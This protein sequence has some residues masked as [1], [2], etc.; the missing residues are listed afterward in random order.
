M[1]EL[2]LHQRLV[3]P[4]PVFLT[5]DKLDKEFARRN[6]EAFAKSSPPS[7]VHVATAPSIP[8]TTARAFGS[9]QHKTAERT[10]SA[11]KIAQLN[12]TAAVDEAHAKLAAAEQVCGMQHRRDG[13]SHH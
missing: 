5:G 1:R 8:P 4:S 2:V 9:E 11:S 7:S 12:F 6:P 3:N 10:Q 13:R